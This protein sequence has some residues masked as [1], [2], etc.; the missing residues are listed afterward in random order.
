[1]DSK[2]KKVA[3]KLSN[4]EFKS[5]KATDELIE[6]IIDQAREQIDHIELEIAEEEERREPRETVINKLQ[7][8]LDYLKKV[9]KNGEEYL[10]TLEKTE[11]LFEIFD[12]E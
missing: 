11:E 9:V 12:E 1:M 2:E 8:Q 3:E 4:A 7:Q 5:I 10:E 6:N